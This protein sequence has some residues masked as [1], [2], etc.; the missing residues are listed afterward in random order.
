LH[1]HDSGLVNVFA[2]LDANDPDFLGHHAKHDPKVA[3]SD[4]VMAFE[5]VPKRLGPG[6][7]WPTLQ[8]V[9]D[10]MQTLADDAR[11][12]LHLQVCFGRQEHFGHARDCI[13]SV[14]S[15]NT[16]RALRS[17]LWSMAEL[18][19]VSLELMRNSAN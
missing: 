18:S 6:S 11:K 14:Y 10:V 7:M 13:K 4:A 3:G 1:I 2:L 17:G 19:M 5:S 12:L 8:S 15:V 9:H 16:P